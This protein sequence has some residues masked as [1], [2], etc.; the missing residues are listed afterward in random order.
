MCR[1]PWVSLYGRQNWTGQHQLRLDAQSSPASS[2]GSLRGSAVAQLCDLF[3]L[4]ESVILALLNAHQIG[5]CWWSYVEH[6]GPLCLWLSGRSASACSLEVAGSAWRSISTGARR[7][8]PPLFH[9]I[10]LQG[11]QRGT[12]GR[13]TPSFG[14]AS[15]RSWSRCL[16]VGCQDCS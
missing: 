14:F 15:S 12:G 10:F 9:P 3:V 16:S 11:Y 6:M 13:M 1:H 7:W 4:L 5:A 8:N 2:Q